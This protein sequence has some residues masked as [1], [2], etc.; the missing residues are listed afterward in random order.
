MPSE[1]NTSF[2]KNVLKLLNKEKK[3]LKTKR[4]SNQKKVYSMLY[5]DLRKNFTRYL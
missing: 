4:L 2:K 1:D 5:Q 3:I